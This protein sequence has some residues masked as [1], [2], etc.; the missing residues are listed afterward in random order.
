MSKATHNKLLLLL[1]C[2]A[3]HSVKVHVWAGISRKE[4]THV[5]VFEGVM[6]RFLYV[7]I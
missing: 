1:Y 7:E 2:R 4:A 5:C 6:D 3:K